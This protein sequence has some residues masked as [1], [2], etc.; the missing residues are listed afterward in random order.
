MTSEDLKC[1]VDHLET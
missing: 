1:H